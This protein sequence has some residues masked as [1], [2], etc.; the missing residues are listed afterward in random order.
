LS[1]V[2]KRIINLEREA[3]EFGFYWPDVTEVMK[4]IRSECDEVD[5]LLADS[6]L[7]KQRLAEEIGDLLHAVFSLCV[8]CKLDPHV[9]LTDATNKFEKRL[10]LTK[11]FAKEDGHQN[12]HG[13]AI[14]EMMKY[15]NKAKTV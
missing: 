14:D 4:Q 10:T 1:D 3:E 13:K 7:L 11:S 2:I 12:L 15:W 9:V 6:A 8:F 5:E